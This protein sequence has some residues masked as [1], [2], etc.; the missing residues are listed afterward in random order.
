MKLISL[1]L[2]PFACIAGTWTSLGPGTLF[3]NTCTPNAG[4]C[5][6]TSCS[7]ANYAFQ[8]SCSN[9]V[10][11]WSGGD[12]YSNGTKFFI[13]GGGHADYLGNEA[14]TV[15]LVGKT[16]ANIYPPACFNYTGSGS[17]PCASTPMAAEALPDGSPAPRHTYGGLVCVDRHSTCYNFSG[18][19]PAGRVSR[20]MWKFPM[21]GTASTDWVQTAQYSLTASS[22]NTIS[23]ADY[24]TADAL[25]CFLGT[26]GPQVLYSYSYSSDTWTPLVSGG[27]PG[28]VGPFAASVVIDNSRKIA[29]FVGNSQDPAASTGGM[30]W[31]DLTGADGYTYHDV[32]SIAN[33]S[34]NGLLLGEYPGLAADPNDNMIVGKAQEG[35]AVYVLNP[36]T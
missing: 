6:G 35:T 9:R 7:S 26:T 11:A 27:F 25:Y 36:K 30:G 20:Y 14:A 34:C 23:C 18:G 16:I 2:L 28:G 21:S 1:L 12:V 33:A 31:I 3:S 17:T 13:W 29:V 10:D 5:T 8:T 22:P 24:P 15:D 4:S 32:T 19:L